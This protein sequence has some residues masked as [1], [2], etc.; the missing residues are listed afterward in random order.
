MAGET[1][2]TLGF[3]SEP[4][5]PSGFIWRV[6]LAVSVGAPVRGSYLGNDVDTN[7]NPEWGLP[8]I[9]APNTLTIGRRVNSLT[10]ATSDLYARRLKVYNR[11]LTDAELIAESAL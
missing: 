2:R 7:A 1:S 10:G 8:F 9:T 4:A 5:Y 11:A 6:A 3:S